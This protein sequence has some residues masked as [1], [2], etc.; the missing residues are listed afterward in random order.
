LKI[1]FSTVKQFL[2]AAILASAASASSAAPLFTYVLLGENGRPVVRAIVDGN[3]CPTLHLDGR[4]VRMSLRVAAGTPPLRPTASG[5]AESKPSVFPVSVC[6]AYIGKGDR[7][8]A[9]DGVPLPLPK[10]VIRRIVVIGDTGCRVKASDRAAQAC[11]DPAQYPFARIAASAAAWKPDLVLHVGDYL[12]RETPCPADAAGCAGTP[13]GYGWDAWKAD[14]FDPAAPLLTA[15]PLALS[16]GNHETCIRAGQG[17]RRFLDVFKRTPSS[18]CDDPAN[19]PIGDYTAPFAI[20]LGPQ[21]QLVMFDSANTPAK[22]LPADDSRAVAYA[23]DFDQIAALTRRVPHT[24]LVNHHPLLAFAAKTGADG[25]PV[26]S[27]GNL[28]LQSVFLRKTPELFPPGV[29]VLL[30]GHVHVWED[31]SFDGVYPAQFVAGFSGTQEDIVP[32]PDAI[33]ADETPAPGATVKAFS[34]WVDG[35]GYMTME[36]KTA[37]R[38]I[39]Q[40]RDTAGAV[41]NTCVIVGKKS[42]CD[43]AKVVHPS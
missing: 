40:V 18:D 17:W 12:Y 36:R 28:G 41:V 33:P 22:P 1:L 4:R 3:A 10:A 24:L 20:P 27:P 39:V 30:S 43:H 6:E 7:S 5:P 26:L 21:T 29:D 15:A 9:I 14:F 16:R 32:L 38:W 8:A 13:W 23:Q 31:I 42:K 37:D 25:A 11:N 34:S 35:F 19:D 2:V